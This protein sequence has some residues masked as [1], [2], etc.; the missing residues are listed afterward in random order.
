MAGAEGGCSL[1]AMLLTLVLVTS[2]LAALKAT[3]RASYNWFGTESGLWDNLVAL[4]VD[5]VVVIVFI[6]LL[7]Q[8]FSV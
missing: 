8:D 2:I 5:F 6:C 3:N 1:T 4:Q 7:R